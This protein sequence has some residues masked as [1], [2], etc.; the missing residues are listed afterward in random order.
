[1]LISGNK[2]VIRAINTRCPALLLYEPAA[3]SG[4]RAPKILATHGFASYGFAFELVEHT[5]IAIT[6]ESGSRTDMPLDLKCSS[7]GTSTAC[8]TVAPI[9]F[10]SVKRL[11]FKNA[12]GRHLL[13][14]CQYALSNLT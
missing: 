1:M 9:V 4:R 7:T 10:W 13:I 12:S 14:P 11:G 5:F 3:P 8:I 6:Y 2:L